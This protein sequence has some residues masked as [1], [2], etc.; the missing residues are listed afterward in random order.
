MKRVAKGRAWTTRVLT[1]REN[2]RFAGC[3][4][5]R[6]PCRVH[7][8]QVADQEMYSGA[9]FPPLEMRMN[10]RHVGGFVWMVAM[11]VALPARAQKVEE[12]V[13]YSCHD[14][15]NK[16][17]NS[18]HATVSCATCHV[19]HEN[20]PHPADV[21]KPACATCHQSVVKDYDQGVHAQ[22]ARKGNASAPDCSVCHGNAHELVTAKSAAFRKSVPDTCGMC[23]SAIADEYR[24]SVHGQAIARGVVDAPVCTTCHGEHSILP[25]T[26]VASPVHSTNIPGT[27][28]QCHANVRLARRFGLPPRPRSELPG[29]VPRDGTEVRF[30]N[31]CQ[32]LQLPWCP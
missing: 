24:S 32:L 22:A 17:K 14:Q 5:T 3:G 13:C 9:G 16:L 21:P 23:H 12:P 15:Q 4:Y 19:R 10:W 29:F 28:A 30:G 27:C 7:A 2:R 20:Y 11:A 8:P 18:A 6:N 1:A 26:N 25:P 31:G